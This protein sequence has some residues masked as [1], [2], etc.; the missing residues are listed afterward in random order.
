MDESVVKH[1]EQPKVGTLKLSEAI[2][3]GKPIVGMEN[4]NTFRLCAL[5]CAWA[6]VKGRVL[7][8]PEH[9]DIVLSINAA[10]A[11]ADALGF[12]R[13]VCDQV[14]RLHSQGQSALAIADILEAE[15][16]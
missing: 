13:D 7:Y 16:N 1:L 15:G 2:R 4:K 5:G 10:H 9:F 3:K 14:S 12:D 6:G 11:M 8:G